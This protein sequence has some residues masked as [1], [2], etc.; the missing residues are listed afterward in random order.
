MTGEIYESGIFI[1]LIGN[2]D[3]KIRM[4]IKF[5]EGKV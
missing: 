1:S 3:S 5:G 4:K 2:E